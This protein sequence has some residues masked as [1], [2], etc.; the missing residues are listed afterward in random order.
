MFNVTMEKNGADKIIIFGDGTNV[1][2]LD[3]IDKLNQFK[4]D[5]DY[6]RINQDT[7]V[8]YYIV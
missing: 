2:I 1:K 4:I 8:G 7:P 6:F 5:T 3:S